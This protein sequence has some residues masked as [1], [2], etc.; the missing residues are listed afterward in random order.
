MKFFN[1]DSGE[2]N[3]KMEETKTTRKPRTR[4]A[5]QPVQDA[6]S[7]P[8][9]N[10]NKFD[11]LDDITRETL[12]AQKPKYD[13]SIFVEGIMQADGEIILFVPAAKRMKW[14]RMD[15]PD[16]VVVPEPPII[17]NRRV[18]VIAKVYKTKEDLQNNLPAAV[19]MA[20]RFAGDGDIYAVDSCATRAQ[21]R[22]LRDLGYDVPMD[23]HIIEGWTPITQEAGTSVNEDALES[24]ISVG[25]CVPKFLRDMAAPSV[26][27]PEL[28]AALEQEKA[29][30]KPPMA[31]PKAAPAEPKP[32]TP[33]APAPESEPAPVV[34]AAEAPKPMPSV[35]PV[36]PMPEAD[37]DP[38]M[39]KAHEQFATL[40]DA[41]AYTSRVLGNRTVGEQPDNRVAYYAKNAKVGKG[42]DELLGLAML[43]VAK[44]RNLAV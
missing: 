36:N 9:Q 4:K 18:T 32:V 17:N 29:P 19:N 25:D 20:S 16:G 10:T 41:E 33:S 3:T 11:A 39:Q 28:V 5:A 24:G 8:A 44:A 15:Y 22:A 27:T 38:L 1:R 35:Q 40:A 12:L 23:A 6:A 26:R 43:L 34:A 31:A 2:R 13:P 7:E 14:F 30:E 37:D 42:N 21:S